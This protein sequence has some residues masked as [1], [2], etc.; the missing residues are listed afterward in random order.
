MKNF[1][2]IALGLMVGAMAIGFSA[3]S[4]VTPNQLNT[5]YPVQ[6][7]GSNF[8]WQQVNPNDYGCVSGTAACSGYQS[9]TPPADNT[10]PSG[11]ITTNQVLKPL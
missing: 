8:S 9:T 6:T 1:K 10:I 7:T 2:K 5:Y 4:N 11:Y 3:F